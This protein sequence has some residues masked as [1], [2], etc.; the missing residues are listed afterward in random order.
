MKVMNHMDHLKC[1][2]VNMKIDKIKISCG[3]LLIESNLNRNE[4]LALL[5]IIESEENIKILIRIEEQFNRLNAFFDRQSLLRR[6]I[7]RNIYSVM[8]MD[9]SK[10]NSKCRHLETSLEMRLCIYQCKLEKKEAEYNLIKANYK[11]IC[12]TSKNQA[13]CTQRGLK[14]IYKIQKQ[15]LDIQ[16]VIKYTEQKLNKN[17]EE[18]NNFDD[19]KY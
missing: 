5:N 19:D 1:S 17:S 8:K 16:D 4:K 13:G 9:F 14:K 18:N 3:K 7:P 15:I 2:K 6:F 10:C 11:N 12:R